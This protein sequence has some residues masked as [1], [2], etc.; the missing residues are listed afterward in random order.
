MKSIWSGSLSFGLVNIPVRVYPASEERSLEFD[1]LH[2]KDL[3]PI[4]YARICKLDGQEIP[5]NEIVKGFEYEKGEYVVIN[6]EDFK[7]ANARKTKTIDI[8]NFTF[9][10]TIDPIF[11]EKPYFLEPDKKADKAYSLLREALGKSKKVAVAKYVFRNKEHIG[12]VKSFNNLLILIQMRYFSEVRSPDEL[13]LPAEKT[14]AKEIDVALTLIEQLTEPFQPEKY[15]D[16]FTE[17]IETIIEAKLQGKKPAR[18]T[19]EPVY[20]RASDLMELLKES[21][22]KSLQDTVTQKKAKAPH[23]I[24]SPT[25]RKVATKRKR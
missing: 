15:H 19:K 22:Q 10:D 23:T 8:Q 18:K 7:T 12:V 2:K 13:S 6:D 14:T 20:T 21:V 11:F 4:R 9:I 3:S 24:K 25:K 1:M 5:Y 16:T 17:E